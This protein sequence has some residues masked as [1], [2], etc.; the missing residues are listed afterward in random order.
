M[1]Q[2]KTINYRQDN[3]GCYHSGPT[4]ICAGKVGKQHGVEIKRLD[5]SDPQGG[6]GACDRK[7]ATIKAHMQLYLNSG[8]DIETPAQMCEAMVYHPSIPMV[9]HPSVLPCASQSPF[10][11]QCL[12]T[13]SMV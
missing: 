10:L 11:Q 13:S 8:H 12:F 9:Y 2:L 7:A 5:F 3:A 1:P 4:I 6:K